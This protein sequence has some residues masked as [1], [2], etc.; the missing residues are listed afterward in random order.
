MPYKQVCIDPPKVLEE[1]PKKADWVSSDKTKAY[2]KENNKI[3]YYY[4][5]Q[6]CKGWIN[7][8]PNKYEEN[9][10]APLA[11]RIGIVEHCIRCGVEIDFSGMCS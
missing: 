9:P 1:L 6:Y 5:C 8:V 11:G 10:L 3:V 2:F 7:G 4:Y